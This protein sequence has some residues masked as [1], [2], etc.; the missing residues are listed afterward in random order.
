MN[1]FSKR[2]VSGSDVI[3][4]FG[5][6]IFDSNNKRILSD[7]EYII[8]VIKI[9]DNEK[10]IIRDID[11]DHDAAVLMKIML[12]TEKGFD[13]IIEICNDIK[14]TFDDIKNQI[15]EMIS[16]MVI[17]EKYELASK[18]QNEFENYVKSVNE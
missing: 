12:Y 9:D 4:E 14:L 1:S 11:S 2:R 10:I 6:N 17:N 7:I 3:A 8:T 5:D 13:N 16:V 15:E 18:L